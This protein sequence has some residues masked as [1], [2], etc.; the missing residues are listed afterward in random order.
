MQERN[1]VVGDKLQQSYEDVPYAHL[2]YPQAH[3]DRLGMLATIM[4]MQPAPVTDCRV[5]ELECA[6]GGNIIPMAYGLPESR[7]L[8]I[9]FSPGR[10]HNVIE[11]RR[12]Y[13]V[14]HP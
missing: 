5:L 14:H 12:K 9:D 7:F 8:G 6:V 3:P 4:E 2:S 10:I 1:K 13:G 11:L